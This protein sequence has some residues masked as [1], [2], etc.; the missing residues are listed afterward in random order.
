MTV[1]QLNRSQFGLSPESYH[2]N[3]GTREFE[4]PAGY[5]L[6]LAGEGI[7]PTTSMLGLLCGTEMRWV[8]E[9]P[10]YCMTGSSSQWRL[11]CVPGVQGELP[12]LHED[13]GG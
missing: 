8:S 2:G 12:V 13:F 9:Q 6:C 10:G 1:N 7:M 3:Y 11:R 5:R 4:I